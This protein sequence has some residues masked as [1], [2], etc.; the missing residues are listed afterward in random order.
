MRALGLEW[1]DLFPATPLDGRPRP[2]RL[3]PVRP[4][5]EK[6]AFA[7]DLHAHDLTAQ[8]ENILRVAAPCEDC[9]T[10]TDADRDL[11]MQ[12]VSR[13]YAYQERAIFCQQYADHLRERAYVA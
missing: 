12:A 9:D 13:A 6:L 8:A 1:P 5:P 3:P 11:A 10:W 7:F 2:V 4:S